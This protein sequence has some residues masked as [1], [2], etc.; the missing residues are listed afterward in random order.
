MSAW[1][2]RDDDS[3]DEPNRVHLDNMQRFNTFLMS[4]RGRVSVTRRVPD[5]FTAV[6]AYYLSSCLAPS[7]EIPDHFCPGHGLPHKIICP[8]VDF[9]S[10]KLEVA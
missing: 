3:L 9:T 1:L 5:A 7:S 10:L 4:S 6:R 8:E 2:S